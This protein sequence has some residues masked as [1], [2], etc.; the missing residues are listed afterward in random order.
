MLIQY[1]IVHYRDLSA[2]HV[3]YSANLKE[4]IKVD[5]SEEVQ[6]LSITSTPKKKV[7]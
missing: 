4:D 7:L 3:L 1:L 5:K 6:M 2:R